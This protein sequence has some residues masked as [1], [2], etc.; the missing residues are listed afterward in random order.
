MAP[1]EDKHMELTF[2]IDQREE[3]TEVRDDLPLDTL[4]PASSE[5]VPDEQRILQE[6][7]AHPI[8]T[9]HLE[10][11]VHPG[12]KVVIVTSDNTRSLPSYKVLPPVLKILAGA[13][14]RDDDIKIIFA[15]GSHRFE[16]EQEQEELVG[17]DVYARYHCSDSDTEHTYH[18][19]DTKAGT[20][21]DID[22]RL[23]EADR[24]ICLGN[25]EYHYFAGFSG[26]AKAI[27]PGC[28][29]RAAIEK[30]HRFMVRDEARAGRLDGNP[31]REDLEEAAAMVPVDFIVNV[32]LNTKKQIVYAAAGDLRAAHRDACRHLVDLYAMPIEKQADI[33]IVSQGGAPKDRNLYQTQKAL[34]NSKYA[35]KQGGVVILCGSCKEGFGEPHFEAFMKQYRDP[36]E[37][38]Q[39]LYDHFVLGSHKAAAIAMVQ[40]RAEIYLV[41]DLPDGVV[42]QTF[43][44]PFHSL[45][46]A[47]AAAQ[48]K[49]NNLGTVIAMP[50]GGST[51]PQLKEE[52][53]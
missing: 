23:H 37:M 25:V 6:A 29:T 28:S 38:I 17:R 14:I 45:S 5:E 20:P 44:K 47:Y 53:A 35:V 42:S 8:G 30:N 48:Q 32:V 36:E 41:S 2:R 27:M 26:G 51:L 15:R 1:F 18:Y 3:K 10:D 43:L 49:F 16:T 4:V 39:A 13:G 11:I 19:G 50:Y 46:E 52:K 33:V 22:A 12:E 34:D 7:L 9:E 40:K 24:I 31:V 21:V